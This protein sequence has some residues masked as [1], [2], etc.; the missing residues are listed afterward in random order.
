M[1][2][3]LNDIRHSVRLLVRTP[4]FTIGA[5]AT[6]ALGI[7][8]N[9][10]IFSIIN[11]VLLK[12]FGYPDPPRIVMFQSRFQQAGIGGTAS[13]TEFNVWRRQSTAFQDVSA[14]DF[15]VANLTGVGAPEQIPVMRVSAD[16][17][18]LT[19]ANA[20]RG[21]IFTSEDD[22]PNAPGT[23]LLSY[24]FWQRHFAGDPDVIGRHI[25]LG[26]EGREIVGVMGSTLKSSQV[27]ELVLRNG[28]VEIDKSPDIYLPFRLD[29]DSTEHGHYFN[30]IGRL[31]PGVTIA[32][33]NA[34]LQATY[35]DYAR[36]WPDDTRARLGFRVRPMQDPITAGVQKPLVS[37]LAAVGFVMA[38]ACANVANLLLARATARKREIAIRSALGGSRA[39]IVRQL[40]TESLVLSLAGCVLGIAGGEAGVHII[41]SLSPGNIPRIGPGG[42]GVSLDWRVLAFS[43]GLSLLSAIFFGIVPALQVSRE[44][45]GGS[46]KEGNNRAGTSLRHTKTRSLLVAAEVAMAVVLLIGAGLLIRTLIAIGHVHP[47]FDARNV[48]TVR[49]SLT[50]P[51]FQTQARVAEVIRDGIH[52]LGSLP[53]VET[54]AAACCV[55]LE[56]R[57]FGT[58]EIPGRPEGPTSRGGAG[59]MSVSAGYFETF[60]IPVLRGRTFTELDD[61][62]PPVAII[63]ETIARQFWPDTDPLNGQIILGRPR[64][65]IGV[66]ADVRDNALTRDPR[67]GVYTLSTQLALADVKALQDLPLAWVI[68]TR[69]P[70]M[71]LAPMVE[72]ELQQASG[73]LPVAQFRTMEEVLSRSMGTERFNA[74]VLT[75]FGCA[76]LLLAV[77]GIYGLMA[78]SV[79]HRMREFSIRMALGA[80][81]TDIIK[82]VV[83]QGFRPVLL[84]LTFGLISAAV[85]T[86]FIVSILFGIKP[87]DPLLF[88]LIPVLLAC[89]AFIAALMPALRA[90]R[91]DPIAALRY[92]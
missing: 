35:L 47:G 69:V 17:F 37:L 77:V 24:A 68:R 48:L 25:T 12:P 50:G 16:F 6:L 36:T 4:S 5:V 31:K 82:D 44:D 42:S 51:R 63:S 80:Q 41:L 54:A 67:P 33:A 55:P 45:L 58:F 72:K 18:Q 84:G 83:S 23:V 85:L 15:T 32:T 27:S 30:V 14:Y 65:I 62:G 88:F 59:A 3:F 43:V 49:M 21:R 8:A 28:D 64:K 2:A 87:L 52:R 26:G 79:S 92:E 91:I 11:T 81:T 70:P 75:I 10:A 7:A 57:L 78:Y 61:N 13:P 20:A 90:S 71:S 89:T 60:K 38:I 9:T 76:A 22:Q 66:V 19:G 34:E 40:M 39:R 53:G 29:P 46:L 56:D 73:G 86:R 1:K 74:L